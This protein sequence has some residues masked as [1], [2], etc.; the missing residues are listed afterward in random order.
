M[1]RESE[2]KNQDLMIGLLVSFRKRKG[3]GG[4]I[5]LS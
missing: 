2:I 5:Y 3:N 1:K 4:R